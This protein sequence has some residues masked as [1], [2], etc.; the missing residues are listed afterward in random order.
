MLIYFHSIYYTSVTS[1]A[2]AASVARVQAYKSHSIY[3]WGR[4]HKDI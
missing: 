2:S 3:K 4:I 1:V